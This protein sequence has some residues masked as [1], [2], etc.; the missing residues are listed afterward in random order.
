[1]HNSDAT[2]YFFLGWESFSTFAHLFEKNGWSSKSC[3]CMGHLLRKSLCV[4]NP[5][6]PRQE[7]NLVLDLRRV[8]CESGTLQG[9][10]S[11]SS[12]YLA[13]ELNLVLQLRTLPCYPSHSQGTFVN[14]YPDL[15][16]NQDLD[17][18]RVQCD[19]LHHR[20]VTEPTTGF[21]P[22]SSGLRDRRLSQSSHVGIVRNQHEREDSNPMRRL[23]RPLALPGAHSCEAQEPLLLSLVDITFQLHIPVRLADKLRPAFDPHGVS[24][25]Q[26]LP[27]RTNRRM[28]HLQTGLL[29][30][31]VGLALVATSRT[32]ARSFPRSK[33]RPAS[34]APR[35]RSSVR[36]RPAARRNTGRSSGPA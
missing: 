15:E 1:M 14:Q 20:D 6:C 29:W 24:G 19:P 32:P 25:V 31:A 3:L 11:S 13:E 22:A 27:Q 9:Q 10:I 34:A 8:A 26:R 4:H 28:A 21:A 17:L 7:L 2:F 33:C 16:S 30:R 12:K 23:W 5:Q 35:G 36:R 18:R